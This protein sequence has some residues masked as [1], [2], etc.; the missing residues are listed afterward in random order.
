MNART[1]YVERVNAAQSDEDNVWLFLLEYFCYKGYW[2][3]RTK[4]TV[5]SIKFSNRSKTL[6]TTCIRVLISAAQNKERH[7]HLQHQ[8]HVGYGR[9]LFDLSI[10]EITLNLFIDIY[11]FYVYFLEYAR[12]TQVGNLFLQQCTQL[13][14]VLKV[15]LQLYGLLIFPSRHGR[16]RLSFL[17]NQ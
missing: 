12:H 11:V 3:L 9:F 14:C 15:E 10:S 1:T 2:N 5:F 17:T 6:R 7:C 8:K 4:K 13:C 16:M